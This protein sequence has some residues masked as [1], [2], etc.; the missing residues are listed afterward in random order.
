[1]DD[2]I[3]IHNDKNEIQYW[4]DCISKELNK[5]GLSLNEKKSKVQSLSKGFLYLGFI[6]KMTS[7][8]KIIMTL[9][10]S[11]IK[12]WRR[13]LKRLVLKAKKGEVS[14]SKV[15]EAF[16][17]WKANAMKGNSYKLVCRMEK[18]YKGLWRTL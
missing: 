9:N 15:E 3:I 1:M 17:C 4:M 10:P 13:K 2:L 16:D 18:Y 14:R 11:N 5:L 7:T 6:Y 8:G 12:H